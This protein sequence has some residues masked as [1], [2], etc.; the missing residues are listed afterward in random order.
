MSAKR[1]NLLENCMSRKVVALAPGVADEVSARLGAQGI[2]LA[3]ATILSALNYARGGKSGRPLGSH[4]SAVA[5]IADPDIRELGLCVNDVL[6]PPVPAT[7][8]VWPG[9]TPADLRRRAAR[10]AAAASS[11]AA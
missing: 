8:P 10:A 7:V 3:P 1:S 11:E 2:R 6:D 5:L 4:R 9:D